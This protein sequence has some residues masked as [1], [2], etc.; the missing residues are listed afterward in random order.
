MVDS[1][2]Y[3]KE[4]EWLKS[5]RKDIGTNTLKRLK[6]E[7]LVNEILLLRNEKESWMHDKQ[8][9]EHQ[10]QDLQFVINELQKALRATNGVPEPD[11]K[12]KE[13]GKIVH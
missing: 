7:Q 3:W 9:W 5:L 1:N 11:Y 12:E 2:S 13:N 10:R 6:K 8:L 4:D